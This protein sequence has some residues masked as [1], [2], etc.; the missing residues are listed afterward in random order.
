MLCHELGDVA[1]RD[2]VASA[3]AHGGQEACLD[4]AAYRV[5]VPA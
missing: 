2:V 1:E 3:G 4:P 5:R